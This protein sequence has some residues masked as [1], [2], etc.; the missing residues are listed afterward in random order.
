MII[1]VI[2]IVV[3]TTNNIQRLHSDVD[4]ICQASD[5]RHIPTPSQLIFIK[6]LSYCFRQ[7]GSAWYF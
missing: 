6:R 2:D 7:L 4:V 3:S 5:V 1:N